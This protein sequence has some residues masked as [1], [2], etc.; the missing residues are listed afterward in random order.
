MPP[1][2]ERQ[3]FVCTNERPATDP[4]GCC[5]DKGSEQVLSAL[6]KA[7]KDQG[8][9]GKVRA[10]ASGCLDACS[11]GVSV[12]VY[13]EGV[14]YGKVSQADAEEI[15]ASHLVGGRPVERLRMDLGALKKVPK[16]EK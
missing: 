10:N 9:A 2:Y 15:V 6:K 1:P 7:L 12:V 13:P 16:A 3:V 8:L 11:Q 5:K 14:W 4:R